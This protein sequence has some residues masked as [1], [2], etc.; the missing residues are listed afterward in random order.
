MKNYK[1]LNTRAPRV[2]AYDKVTGKAIYTDDMKKPNMLTAAILHSPLAHAKILNIDTSRAERLAG[3]EAV[4]TYREAGTI[5]YGVSPARY[6]ETIF[7]HDRVRYV[8]DEIA[9]V[10][11]M[12]LDTALE[13]INLIKVDFEEL[14][15]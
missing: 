5:P 8:G 12:D 15:I 14:P 11:A 7:C 10:A 13:A 3:V 1:I 6:D 2:D 4:V 9:A